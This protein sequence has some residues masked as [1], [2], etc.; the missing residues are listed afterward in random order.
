MTMNIA[1]EPDE[2]L[3]QMFR[4]CMVS[5]LEDKPNRKQAED[6]ISK[7]NDVWCRRSQS[8]GRPPSTESPDIGVL[9]VVGY[10]VG[11]S[12]KLS[13]KE[14]HVLLDYVMVGI[15]P[16]VHSS[17][18]MDEWGE[19]NSQARYRKLHRVLASFRTGAANRLELAIAFEEW[20]KD[21]AYIESEWKKRI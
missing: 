18:H 16:F 9:K 11:N 13:P 2:K 4:N 1:K 5:I 10:S 12:S 17:S 19:P 15:L 7:I 8:Q 6:M 14:R 21:V 20:D 3:E